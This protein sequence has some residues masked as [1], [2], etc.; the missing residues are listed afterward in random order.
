MIN[1]QNESSH[2]ESSEQKTDQ[3]GPKE[4]KNVV[5]VG[6]ILFGHEARKYQNETVEQALERELGKLDTK[7]RGNWLRNLLIEQL[8]IIT[9]IEEPELIEKFKERLKEQKEGKAN[10]ELLRPQEE[11]K[12][13]LPPG[14]NA[15]NKIIVP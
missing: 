14:V 4:S 15:S 8:M 13:I 2:I 1:Q 11:S 5:I 12:I 7:E 10:S 3:P 6:E 9:V